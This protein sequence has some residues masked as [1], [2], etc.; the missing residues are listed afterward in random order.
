[1]A[2]FTPAIALSTLVACVAAANTVLLQHISG[3]P[4]NASQVLDSRLASFSFEFSFLPTFAGNTTHPNALTQVS[5]SCGRAR[6]RLWLMFA[7]GAHAAH[8]RAY[9]CRP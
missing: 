7:T 8:C 5:A 6:D 1:M 2:P 9:G 4:S 3:I